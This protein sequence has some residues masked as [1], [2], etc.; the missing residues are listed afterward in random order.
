M[1]IKSRAPVRIDFAG[2][3][4][5]VSYF[6]D[7]FGGATLNAAIAFHVHGS[8]DAHEEEVGIAG[9]LVSGPSGKYRAVGDVGLRVQYESTIPAGSGLGTSATLNVVWLS[10]VRRLP[11]AA[12]EDRMQIAALAYDIEKVLG[13]IGGKQDQYASAMGG[14]NLF[15]FDADDVR[16][17]RLDLPN[18]TVQALEARLVLCYTGKP[19]L[20][21]NIHQHVWGNFRAGR[22]EAVSALFTLRDSAYE[23]K[24][25]LE[26]GD[27]EALGPILT[28]QRDCM[29]ALHPST[30]NKMI[31]ELFELAEPHIL[32]G[33]PC[34][35]GGG[36]CLLFLTRS[37]EDRKTL[38]AELLRRRLTLLDLKFDFEGL[39]VT[40]GETATNTTS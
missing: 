4:T 11:V 13:I 18:E 35:A 5:D 38:V 37:P 8:L 40:E 36:G 19:R 17:H 10:L 14:I 28:S 33:K 25:V 22:Q 21:S 23:A 29:I 16:C 32:G 30:T 31:E 3:W 12:D 26:A 24:A 20:S 1:V 2:A 27:I 7:A 6:A 39:V 9:T 34:G 15:E